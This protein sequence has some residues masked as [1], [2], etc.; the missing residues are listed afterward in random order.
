MAVSFQLVIERER[1]AGQ[2]ISPAGIPVR[3]A[4]GRRS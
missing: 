4:G 3:R 1:G 2:V